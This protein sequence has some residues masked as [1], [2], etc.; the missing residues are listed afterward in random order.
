MCGTLDY[1]PPEMVEGRA[2]NNLVDNWALGVLTYEFVCGISP[3][4]DESGSRGLLHVHSCK[5]LTDP[6]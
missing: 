3:F 6:L 1:L 4:S 5:L 2:H